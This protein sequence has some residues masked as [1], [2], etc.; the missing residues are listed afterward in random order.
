MGEL[1][2]RLKRMVTLEKR[3]KIRLSG[4]TT[5]ATRLSD[6]MYLLG[7]VNMDGT[8]DT[9]TDGGSDAMTSMLI[10]AANGEGYTSLQK[11]LADV[12]LDG[13][14]DI[15]DTGKI[16]K[17]TSGSSETITYATAIEYADA[18]VGDTV[19]VYLHSDTH[20]YPVYAKVWAKGVIAIYSNEKIPL[21]A[22]GTIKIIRT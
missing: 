3:T 22:T 4:W 10:P 9:S 11:V 18:A 2:K 12:N 21:D 19:W 5:V 16:T 15:T 14:I 7:D 20:I 13:T 8:I 6:E 17:M 1:T